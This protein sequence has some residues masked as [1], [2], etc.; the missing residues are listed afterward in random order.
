M[1]KNIAARFD[2]QCRY[3]MVGVIDDESGTALRFNPRNLFRPE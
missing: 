1:C 3:L 2:D